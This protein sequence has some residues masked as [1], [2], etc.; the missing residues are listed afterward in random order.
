MNKN[1]PNAWGGTYLDMH[2]VRDFVA[3]RDGD[4]GGVVSAGG[5]V[6]ARTEGDLARARVAWA[7]GAAR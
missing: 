5:Y 2:S 1:T 6:G 7:R 3:V 4:G